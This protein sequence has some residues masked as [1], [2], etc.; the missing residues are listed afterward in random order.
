VVWLRRVEV[1]YLP[2]AEQERDKLPAAERA[3]LYNAVCK[4]EALGPD[5]GYPHTS[6][7]RGTPGLRE[8]RPRQG[9]S[10]WRALCR[11]AGRCFVIAAVGAEAQSDPRGYRRACQAAQQRLAALEE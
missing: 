5:L 3:A 2:E 10:P 6:D 8:L 7:V 1:R 11:P 9:R 4:L